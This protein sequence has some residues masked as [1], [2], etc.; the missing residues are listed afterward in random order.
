[1]M[2]DVVDVPLVKLQ[3]GD[4]FSLM[5]MNGFLYIVFNAE[6]RRS[7]GEREWAVQSRNDLKM[8]LT[9]DGRQSLVIFALECV[10]QRLHIE[11]WSSAS[12]RVSASVARSSGLDSTGRGACVLVLMV[13]R[14]G[15]K[16]LSSIIGVGRQSRWFFQLLVS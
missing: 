1:M 6:G 9:D 3:P 8:R 13:S 16:K 12:C 5:M 11:G 10:S 2:L 7:G 4:F 14:L 15:R